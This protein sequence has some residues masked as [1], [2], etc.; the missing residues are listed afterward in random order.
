MNPDALVLAIMLLGHLLADFAVP[1][2]VSAE[3]R[4]DRVASLIC[5]SAAWALTTS[6]PIMAASVASP[7]Q[8][9]WALWILAAANVAVRA[10]ASDARERVG[11]IGLWQSQSIALAQ[12]LATWLAYVALRG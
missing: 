6:L 9:A 3:G 4:R 11:S 12:I 8:N 7:F 2:R 10:F 1:W 5:R